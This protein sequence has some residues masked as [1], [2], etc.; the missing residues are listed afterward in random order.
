[1]VEQQKV[2]IEQVQK[3]INNKAELYEAA[4]RNGY[5]LPSIKSSMITEKYLIGIVNGAVWCPQ[6]KDIRLNPCPRPPSKD[7]L[8]N[9]LRNY[10]KKEKRNVEVDEKK[11]P[12]KQWIINILSTYTPNDEIFSRS[13][14]PP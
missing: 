6:Y 5:Y 10:I 9:K 7:V 1:M 2:T 4:V 11:Q 13:Y 14:V 12:D 3:V 8:L